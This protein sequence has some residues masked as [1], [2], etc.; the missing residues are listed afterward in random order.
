MLYRNYHSI[1]PDVIKK[2]HI[3]YISRQI[4]CPH[5]AIRLILIVIIFSEIRTHCH[6]LLTDPRIIIV[7]DFQ[8]RLQSALVYIDFVIHVICSQF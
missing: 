1:K 4:P 3:S 6:Y 7:G 8:C 5:F 2:L